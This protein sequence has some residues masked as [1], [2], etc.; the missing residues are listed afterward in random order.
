MNG[1]GMNSS[2]AQQ[3]DPQDRRAWD[4]QHGETSKAYS[5]FVKYRDQAEKRSYTSVAKELACSLPNILRW[6]RR[7]NWENRAADFD[8]HQDEGHR[9][10]LARG[11][12]AMRRRHLQIAMAMQ[13]IAVVGLRELQAKV[14]QRLPLNLTTDEVRTMMQT[15]AK[16]END[17]LGKEKESRYTKIEV[18]LGTLT[19]E[20]EY[21]PD[22][23]SP[24]T[25][26]GEEKERPLSDQEKLKLN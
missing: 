21:G 17:A 12:L 2:F 22:P 18:H 15:A 23:D 9:A 6:A 4:R 10:E 16:L 3:L 20:E 7:W 26:D 13:E 25:I 5:A 24:T 11:R 19:A 14:Q 1:Y 8:I